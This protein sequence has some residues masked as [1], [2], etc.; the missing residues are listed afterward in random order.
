MGRGVDRGAG[1]HVRA[2]IHMQNGTWQGERT[3]RHAAGGGRRLSRCSPPFLA[4]VGRPDGPPSPA[5][6]GPIRSDGGFD[7]LESTI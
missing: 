3:S 4:I 2:C 6:G 5:S 7:G 1:I